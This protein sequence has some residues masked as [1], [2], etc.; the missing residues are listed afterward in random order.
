M[1]VNPALKRWAILI[2]SLRDHPPPEL[3]L[4]IFGI[5]RDACRHGLFPGWHFSRETLGWRHGTV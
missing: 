2:R 1:W 5:R 3:A 4:I